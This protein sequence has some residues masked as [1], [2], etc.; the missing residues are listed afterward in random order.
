MYTD[1]LKYITINEYKWSFCCQ[2][3]FGGSLMPCKVLNS[4]V[5]TILWESTESEHRMF[6]R[7]RHMRHSIPKVILKIS[8]SSISRVYLKYYMQRITS[9]K[10]NSVY[11]YNYSVIKSCD[12]WTEIYVQNWESTF[13]ERQT[14][15]MSHRYLQWNLALMRHIRR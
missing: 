2:C 9:C 12:T 4:D 8:F 5:I 13:N 14:R 15:S 3:C 1:A 6:F 11:V 10:I 7:T